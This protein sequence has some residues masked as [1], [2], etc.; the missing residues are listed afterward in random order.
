VGGGIEKHG[1]ERAVGVR[2]F[3]RYTPPF[4]RPL[5]RHRPSPL[6][7]D[8]WDDEDVDAEFDAAL[9]LELE[10]TSGVAAAAGGGGSNSGGG[11]SSGGGV[12]K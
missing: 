2:A 6:R 1:R 4:A 9:A 12:G 8:D 5:T 7:S 10:K 3:L 11:A